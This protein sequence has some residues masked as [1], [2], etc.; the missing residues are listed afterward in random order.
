MRQQT[1]KSF[2]LLAVLI[3]SV[4]TALPVNAGIYLFSQ[5]GYSGGGVITGWFDAIDT[6]SNGQIS[7]FDSEVSDFFLSF[8][9]DSFVGDFTHTFADLDGLVYDVG[10]GFIGDGTG[11]YVEG[12]ASSDFFMDFD[13]ASGL[14]GLGVYGGMVWES[15]EEQFS[16]TNN[17]IAVTDPVVV[18][19]PGAIWLSCS[20]L[21][22]YWQLRRRRA[23]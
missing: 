6:S 16:F 9:G 1:R 15:S 4:F 21:L 17:M 12:M 22:G 13:Y 11:G 7:S 14:G 5:D 8:S 2:Y 10:S 3:L 19:V 23:V 20:G 18:P